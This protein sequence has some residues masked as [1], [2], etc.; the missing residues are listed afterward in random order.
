MHR[1]FQISIAYSICQLFLKKIFIF[2]FSGSKNTQTNA[3]V[4]NESLLAKTDLKWNKLK[5]PFFSL[6]YK[7]IKYFIQ[8]YQICYSVC[9]QSRLLG[10]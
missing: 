10:D 7:Y 5:R 8:V 3:C 1:E 9:Y 2:K 4:R 6:L